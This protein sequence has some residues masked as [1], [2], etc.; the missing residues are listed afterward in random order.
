MRKTAVIAMVLFGA[1]CLVFAAPEGK[2]SIESQLKKD[3]EDTAKT[4]KD[5]RKIGSEKPQDLLEK[6]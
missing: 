4:R 2:G 5:L 1:I 3:L 6:K